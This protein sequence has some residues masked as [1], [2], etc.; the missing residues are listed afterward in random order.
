ML[1]ILL[2]GNT[3]QLGWELERVLAPLGTVTALDY[4]TIDLADEEGLRRTVRQA[5]RREEQKGQKGRFDVII[6]AA[7]YTAVDRAES[8]PAL[9]MAV[10]GH[11]PG[12]LA[13]EA[14]EMGAAFMHYSTDYVFDGRKATSAGTNTSSASISYVETDAPNPLG[15]YGKSKLDGEL[16]VK[17]VGGAYLILR[18][19]WVYSLRRDSF[20]TK[21]L[22]W[23][24]EQRT[25]RIVSDQVSNPT[26]ARA[27]AE[28]TAKIFSAGGDDITGWTKERA[29]LYHLAG[30]GYA[31]RF[32]WAREILRLDPRPEEHKVKELVPAKT[33][34][35]PTPSQRPL[36]SALECQ[37][38][39]DAF[40]FRLPAWKDALL[41]T[42]QGNE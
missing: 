14:Y 3:G 7:A 42:L 33:V 2:I 13:E 19:A 27:L 23:A 31:S 40:G 17:K 34:D 24:R 10:N 29:G 20:V 11:A 35:F 16:A 22:H 26:W 21:V 30:D 8:E 25:M 39:E 37:K 32:E 6:N 1:H 36:F 38:F 9:A 41:Q 5:A 28:A 18:T 12:F 4:P 15:V